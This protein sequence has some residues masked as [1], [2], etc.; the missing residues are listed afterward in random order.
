MKE[1][2]GT[3]LVMHDAPMMFED[4]KRI[5]RACDYRILGAS[6]GL[7]GLMTARS[8]RPDLVIACLSAEQASGSEIYR[9]IST[10]PDLCRAPVLFVVDSAGTGR[11]TTEASLSE[12]V[13]YLQNPYQSGHFITKVA[14]LIERRRTEEKMGNRT[15]TAV[16]QA[17]EHYRSIFENAIE[18]MFQSTPDGKFTSVNPA[19]VQLLGF[20]SPEELLAYQQRQDRQFYVNPD[21]QK[22][23]EEQLVANG[24]AVGFKCEVYRKDSSRI[25]I[26]QNVRA[27][28]DEQGAVLYCDGSILDVTE[29]SVLEEQLQQSRKMEAIGQLAGG[30][31]HDFNNLLTAINGYSETALQKLLSCDPLRE[32]LIEIKRAGERAIALT[33][34]LLA[35]SRKQVLQLK[36]LDLN[37]VVTDIEKLL[38]RLIAEDIELRVIPGSELGSIKADPGQIEQ[39]LMN[40]AVNARDA[41]P[42]GGTLTIETQGVYLDEEYSRQHHS[43][44]SGFY[45]MLAVSDTGL[46]MDQQTQMRVFEPF[47][48]TKEE[49]KGTGM[50]LSTVYGV[51]KQ[52]GGHIWVYS[53]LGRGTSFKIYF[54]RIDEPAQ[55]T[56]RPIEA[57]ESTGGSETILLVE[58][59]DAL[60]KLLRAALRKQGYNVL[61]ASNGDAALTAAERAQGPIHLLVSDVIMPGMGGDALARSLE[62]LQPE[63]KVLYISGYTDH[64]VAHHGNLESGEAF[65]QKP[66]SPSELVRKVRE[67][68]GVGGTN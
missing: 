1:D 38:R 42:D 61:E 26:V 34:Q 5:L 43:V 57:G 55:D 65:L 40:L 54:P 53:E 7:A 32:D 30:I 18:G 39:I 8:V 44:K 49:G 33:R 15:E 9:L 16:R 24:A 10:Y 2:Q 25:W 47:F 3:I 59:D 68:L 60:R 19:L 41:M 66:F 12:S 28:R 63:L 17:E 67:I 20:E 35:F 27:V 11:G 29:R 64:A 62:R 37:S 6:D 4:L 23:L 21:C 50:G 48:T 52:S 22:R 36:V 13:E 56:G 51:V 46:G 45:T 31:A 58:D 14:R